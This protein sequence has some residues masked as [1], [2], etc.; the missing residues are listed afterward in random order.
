[1]KR[2]LAAALFSALALAAIAPASAQTY[3]N[4]GRVNAVGLC[5]AVTAGYPVGCAPTIGDT[6][7]KAAV[8]TTLTQF[9]AAPTAGSIRITAAQYAAIESATGGA[10]EIEAG[11]GTNCGTGTVVVSALAWVPTSAVAGSYGNG[12]GAIWILP[13]GDAACAV[14]T[15]GTVT[16][17]EISGTY[18]V[19]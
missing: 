2:L 16:F 7:F 13:A 10:L 8:T 3:N 17:A 4:S 1:M 19:Y 14:I 15:A 11:T 6:A 18:A 12:S 5:S 9:I